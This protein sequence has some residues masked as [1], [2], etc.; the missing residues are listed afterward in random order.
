MYD[1]LK[2]YWHFFTTVQ[3]WGDIRRANLTS[4]SSRFWDCKN[5][6]NREKDSCKTTQQNWSNLNLNKDNVLHFLVIFDLIFLIKYGREKYIEKEK[7]NL[8]FS[9]FK[10]AKFPW[11]TFLVFYQFRISSNLHYNFLWF[12]PFLPFDRKKIRSDLFLLWIYWRLQSNWVQ[13][14]LTFDISI[15]SFFFFF[16]WVKSS[17]KLL[18]WLGFDLW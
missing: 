2:V 13:D 1:I 17:D 14:R 12:C 3:F 4:F 11:S 18:G 8:D 7:K 16:A 15:G 5:I 9:I 6:E 10:W